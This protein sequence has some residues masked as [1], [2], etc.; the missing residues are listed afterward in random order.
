M[1]SVHRFTDTERV[2]EFSSARLDY[3]VQRVERPGEMTEIFEGRCDRLY[4]RHVIFERQV[5]GAEQD[6]VAGTEMKIP[7]VRRGGCQQLSADHCYT[8]RVITPGEG[9][10]LVCTT[11]QITRICIHISTALLEVNTVRNISYWHNNSCHSPR[12]SRLENDSETTSLI[13]KNYIVVL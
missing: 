9:R 7:Q 6:G 5:D 10:F 4:R 11:I 1:V 12:V 2:T 8:L 3:L 13:L